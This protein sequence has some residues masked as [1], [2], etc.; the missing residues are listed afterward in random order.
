MPVYRFTMNDGTKTDCD[1]EPKEFASDKSAVDAAQVA[2]ADMAHDAL[3]D[4]NSVD[5]TAAVEN[6]AGEEIYR[7]SLKF[8]GETAEHARSK[9]ADFE[10]AADDAAEAVARALAVKPD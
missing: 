7:A 9:A 1:N 8:R 5:L 2:L 6:S 3:P 4:G 10:A